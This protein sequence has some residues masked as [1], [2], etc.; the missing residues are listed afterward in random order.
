MA[1]VVIASAMGGAFAQGG[2]EQVTVPFSDP[3]RPGRLRIG[4][5]QGSIKVTGGSRRDVA[6]VARPRTSSRQARDS[7]ADG[8]RRLPQ[9]PA[10]SV[11]ENANE[12]SVQSD[13]PNSVF[14]FE[15]QVPARINLKLSAV[16]NGEI[17]VEGV[18][19]EMVID[20][21]NGGITLT[22]VSGSVVAN[23]TNGDLV[24]TL[25]RVTEQ[26]AMAFT[27]FNGKVD[28]TLPAATKAN[29]RLRS[30][31]NDVFT[32]FDVQL[33]SAPSSVQDTKREGG[34]YRIS[35]NKSIFGSINGGGPDIELRTFNGDVYLR[36][37]K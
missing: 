14:D 26:K 16:N 37:G 24:A 27:S 6:I 9:T 8:L 30:D 23:T 33:R 12:M 15:I 34:R 17:V 25:T 31:N 11:Q 29:L 18:E 19:G 32:D 5:T 10:F 22:G 21:T 13:T 28:V 1:V 36:R 3:S 2:A 4:M 35:V 7:R 20:H